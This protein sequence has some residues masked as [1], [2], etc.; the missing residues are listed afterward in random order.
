MGW[1][2]PKYGSNG[3]KGNTWRVKEGDNTY[4]YLPPMHSLAEDGKWAIYVTV[5]FGYSGPDPQDPTKTRQKPFRCIQVKDFRSGMI[6]ED[7]P[8]CTLYE[9][10][11]KNLEIREAELR[12]KFKAEG[13]KDS[14]VEE[15][16]QTALGPD[17]AWLKAHNADR[18]WYINAMTED[19]KEFGQVAISHRTKSKQLDPLFKRLRE[20]ESI[21]P[22][23][24]EQG[25]LI[26]VKRTGRLRDATD[27]VEV[28]KEKVEVEI[29][30]KKQKLEQ[31]KLR[32]LT[33][34]EAERALKECRDLSTVGG[35]ELTRDQI[36]ELTECDGS[37]EAVDRVFKRALGVPKEASPAPAPAAAPANDNAAAEAAAIQAR[38]KKLQASKTQQAPAA[39]KES[40]LLMDDEAFLAKFG[41][42]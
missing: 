22:L 34:V 27:L 2:K 18:K 23:D 26:N 40:A 25:V 6:L 7:C 33:E 28:V 35:F 4:R 36:R 13:K 30:G 17:K 11:A 29:G 38:L 3:P 8:E 14:E 39:V 19:G 42:A 41:G 15:L 21:D 20:E 37:P 10:N 32:P 5:H 12:T 9:R 24:L 16:L 31:I 1:G